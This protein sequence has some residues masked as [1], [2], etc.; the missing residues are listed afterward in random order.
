MKISAI[1]GANSVNSNTKDDI[2][3]ATL[4]LY[5]QIIEKNKLKSKNIICII[6]SSTVDLTE[7]YPATVIRLNGCTA[8]LFSTTEP[9]IKGSLPQCIR[10]MVLA[11]CKKPIH[12]YLNKAKN[13]RSENL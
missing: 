10:L 5:N 4:E 8:P 11:K 13:L 9:N 2:I 3:L 12:I 6:A 1:R 7:Y